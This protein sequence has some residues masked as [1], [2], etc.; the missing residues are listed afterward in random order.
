[1]EFFLCQILLQV[2]IVFLYQFLYQVGN[3]F[4]YLFLGH[5]GFKAFYVSPKLARRT[6]SFECP[7]EILGAAISLH[8]LR[9]VV[10]ISRPAS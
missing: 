10:I 3:F 2:V 6:D 5:L 9:S 7:L 1:M 4:N 8:A